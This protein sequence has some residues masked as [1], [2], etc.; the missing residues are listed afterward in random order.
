WEARSWAR[1]AR[2][3]ALWL[4]KLDELQRLAEQ[5][6]DSAERLVDLLLDFRRAEIAYLDRQVHATLASIE[7]RA[8]PGEPPDPPGPLV[9]EL[10]LVAHSALVLLG[11]PAREVLLKRYAEAGPGSEEREWMVRTL[12]A[13]G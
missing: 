2:D 8:P 5:N 6:G 7:S 3:P 1:N 12:A 10:V 11:A 9:S 13:M 4:A